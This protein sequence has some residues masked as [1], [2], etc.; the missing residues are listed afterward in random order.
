MGD[1]KVEPFE[2]P[3]IDNENLEVLPVRKEKPRTQLQ[4][5]H[6]GKINILTISMEDLINERMEEA[7]NKKYLQ[8]PYK[9][10][11]CIVAFEFEDAFKEHRDKKHNATEGSIVCTICKTAH[12]SQLSYNDHWKRHMR[13][14]ECAECGKRNKNIPPILGHYNETHVNIP[15]EYS[16]KLCDYRTNSYRSYRYHLDKHRTGNVQ[17]KECGNIFVHT[18][19]LKTHI[20][21]VHKAIAYLHKCDVCGKS[22]KRRSALF[23]HKQTHTQT[24]AYCASCDLTFKTQSTLIQHLKMSSKHVS[25]D[26][27]RFIC[28]ECGKKFLTKASLVSHIDFDH[29]KNRKYSCDKC[30]KVFKYKNGLKSHMLHVHENVRPPRNKICDQCGRGFTSTAILKN[31]IRTHTG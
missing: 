25:D 27:K 20:R 21:A 3:T 29:L 28:D 15:V 18:S 1:L 31:H 13:R 22:Y 17:C 14:Y 16:C 5:N 23:T 11:D 26:L 19:G 2:V 10:T 24:G 30:S 12:S 6:E 9:C 4:A 8:L 7:K